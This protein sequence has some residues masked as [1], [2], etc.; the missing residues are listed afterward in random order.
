MGWGACMWV[1]TLGRCKDLVFYF[2]ARDLHVVKSPCN[3]FKFP[4]QIEN[5]KTV[6]PLYFPLLLLSFFI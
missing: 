5:R 1:H 3:R 6:L 2:V 4:K